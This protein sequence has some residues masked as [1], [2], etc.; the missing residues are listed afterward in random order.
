MFKILVVEDDADLC[1]LFCRAL[2]RSNYHPIGAENAQKALEI[3]DTEY[4]DLIISDVMMG[5]K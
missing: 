4:I 2:S 1:Q 5:H 3:L